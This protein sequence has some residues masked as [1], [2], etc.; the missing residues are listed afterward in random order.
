M[1]EKTLLLG[2]WVASYTGAAHFFF[3]KAK[4]SICGTNV[5]PRVQRYFTHSVPNKCTRCDEL[6]AR[7]LSIEA[8]VV[9]EVLGI[10][11]MHAS[12]EVRRIASYIA[13]YRAEVDRM[14]LDMRQRV[15]RL[16]MEPWPD[17]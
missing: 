6:H 17:R 8:R 5:E 2:E 1:P 4:L 16:G 12:D 15:E 7:E 13:R 3:D 14:L 11:Y 10:P 9:H